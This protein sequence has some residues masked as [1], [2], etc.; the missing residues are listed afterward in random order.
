MILLMHKALKIGNDQKKIRLND[1]F[2]V[3]SCVII[4]AISAYIFV[5]TV[6][7]IWYYKPYENI[8]Q[9]I[10]PPSFC[11]WVLVLLGVLTVN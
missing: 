8:Y 6:I 7:Q 2:Q 11:I 10:F 3:H 9:D 4:P 5:R 1:F